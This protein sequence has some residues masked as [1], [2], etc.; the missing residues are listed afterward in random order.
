MEQE[1]DGHSL[2]DEQEWH[3]STLHAL[4]QEIMQDLIDDDDNISCDQTVRMMLLYS[5]LVILYF[6]GPSR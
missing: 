4:S 1:M 6:S 5:A 2:L 3:N